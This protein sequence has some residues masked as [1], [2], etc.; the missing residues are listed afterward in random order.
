[1]AGAAGGT[2]NPG[3]YTNLGGQPM[4]NVFL[5]M[6]DRMGVQGVERIGDSSGRVTA[7]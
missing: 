6:T 7:V 4:S 1:M 5:S 2:M 3:R